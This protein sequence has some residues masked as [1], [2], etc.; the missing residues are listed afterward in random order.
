MENINMLNIVL[1]KI[2][3]N[4]MENTRARMEKYGDNVLYVTDLT[5]CPIKRKLNKNNVEYSGEVSIVPSVMIGRFTGDGIAN[6]CKQHF[7]DSASQEVGKQK[8]IGNYIIRGRYDISINGQIIEVKFS[9]YLPKGPQ[10]HHALQCQI[11]CWLYD[12]ENVLLWYFSPEGYKEYNI[13]RDGMDDEMI[14]NLIESTVY[15]KYQW[16]CKF[17]NVKE[18]CKSIGN[19]VI[20][21]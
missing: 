18:E 15:P 14:M 6:V 12:V 11:Y 4:S 1:D 13:K 10:K 5:K 19:G 16:E 3:S 9:R 8:E 21:E 7:G 20:L 2:K 17:C